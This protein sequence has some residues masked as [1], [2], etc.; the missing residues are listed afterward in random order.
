MIWRMLE[1][2]MGRLTECLL[3]SVNHQQAMFY[4]PGTASME[5]LALAS[6]SQLIVAS[7]F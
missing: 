5:V 7:I 2:P 6:R 1:M 4:L 3:V